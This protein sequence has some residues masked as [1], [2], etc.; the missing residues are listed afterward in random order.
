MR[1]DDDAQALK[2]TPKP[3]KVTK[4]CHIAEIGAFVAMERLSYRIQ[5]PT[6]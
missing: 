4:L 6:E 2:T 1:S 3:D 5:K